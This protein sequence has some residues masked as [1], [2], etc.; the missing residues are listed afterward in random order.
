VQTPLLVMSMKK[1]F[2][3][4][5][6]KTIHT[7]VHKMIPS[8]SIMGISSDF[9]II[10]KKVQDCATSQQEFEGLPEMIQQLEKIL[11]QSC[12]ELQEELKQLKT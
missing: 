6:W 7:A 9:E 4:K 5:D 8:F 12:D 1:G 11:M 10:A 3:E 2:K